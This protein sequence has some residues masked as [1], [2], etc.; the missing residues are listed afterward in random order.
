M[1]DANAEDTSRRSRCTYYGRQIVQRKYEGLENAG[2][3]IVRGRCMAET[4]SSDGLP[5]FR[6]RPS[7]EHDEH[8]CGCMGWD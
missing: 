3:K 1:S 5:F 2:G 7:R 6:L 8:Y 4:P